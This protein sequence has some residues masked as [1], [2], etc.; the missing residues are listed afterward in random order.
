MIDTGK[1]EQ[2]PAENLLL[3]ALLLLHASLWIS[4]AVPA[5]SVL[6]ASLAMASAEHLRS[7][8]ERDR[9]EAECRRLQKYS[10]RL[11]AEVSVVGLQ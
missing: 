4:W 8:M 1:T 9:L 7:R 3:H 11:T 6:L 2:L 10:M 5:L